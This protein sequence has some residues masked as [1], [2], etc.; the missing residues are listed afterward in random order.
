[1]R[2]HLTGHT[3]EI[4]EGFAQHASCRGKIVRLP[5]VHGKHWGRSTLLRGILLK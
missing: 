2:H 3:S 5:M 1:M 4:D